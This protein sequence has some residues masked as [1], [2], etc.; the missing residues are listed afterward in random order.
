MMVL[1]VG[2]QY[3]QHDSQP[4]SPIG[5]EPS[6]YK[7][8]SHG[9]TGTA[10]P[11]A[12]TISKG[13]ERSSHRLA[14]GVQPDRRR[15]M[16]SAVVGSRTRELG[17]PSTQKG[18]RMISRQRARQHVRRWANDAGLLAIV[19]VVAF[20]LGCLNTQGPDTGTESTTQPDIDYDAGPGASR[21]DKEDTDDPE[22][23]ARIEALTHDA[24]DS[25]HRAADFLASQ[26]RFRVVADVT[27]DVV[28]P[29]GRSIEFGGR[30]EVTI[31]RPDRLRMTRVRRDG[32][33][34]SL[35]FD[36]S[37]ISIDLPGQ[38][39][40]VQLDHP[41]TL[42][43]AVDHLVE[44]LGAPFALSNLI[45]ENLAA[46]F[47]GQVTS[48]YY[49][50]TTEVAGRT[51]EHLSYRLADVD[52][53]LWIEEGDRPLIVRIVISYKNAEGRPQFRATLREWDLAPE[54]PDALFEFEPA[55]GSERLVVESI[56]GEVARKEATQ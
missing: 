38:N 6:Q 20:A 55:E 54:T 21:L 2:D 44:N 26:S 32:D 10:R 24:M 5:H 39:A 29:D 1:Q 19:F 9:M 17:I 22:A 30:R 11:E 13:V 34:R 27:F 56:F 36:G 37:T 12:I 16:A 33:T 46:P 40:F 42:Y 51:C 53:Q 3:K 48:S 8:I 52:L 49:A 50:G 47:E 45:S 41:G 35:Y 18:N 23:E 31:R 43:A 15:V 4:P 25:L 28:Q 14:S 7:P